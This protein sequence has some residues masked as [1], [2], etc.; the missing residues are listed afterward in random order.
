MCDIVLIAYLTLR[1]Y[2]DG[3]F[4]VKA[5]LSDEANT[6]MVADTLDR[7]EIPFFGKLASKILDDE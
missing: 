4:T 2:R 1:A 3:E 7:C 6:V 5:V